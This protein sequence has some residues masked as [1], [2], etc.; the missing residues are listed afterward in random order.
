M[1]YTRLIIQLNNCNLNSQ[2]YKSSAM[3]IHKFDHF[4]ETTRVSDLISSKGK[5]QGTLY[6]RKKTLETRNKFIP[7]FHKRTNDRS[8]VYNYG[9]GKGV[10]K[11]E[12]YTGSHH[13]NTFECIFGSYSKYQSRLHICKYQNE[14]FFKC[15]RCKYQGRSFQELNKHMDHHCKNKTLA[16]AACN[17]ECFTS[18]ELKSD[19]NNSL[20]CSRC[21]YKCKTLEEMSMHLN[22]HANQIILK[23][24]SCSYTCFARS[25][26]NHYSTEHKIE[27][28]ALQRK[29]KEQF[30]VYE[31]DDMEALKCDYC[32]C[33]F[34]KFDAIK[35]NNEKNTLKQLYKCFLCGYY[36]YK[37]H[38]C[39][40]NSYKNIDD[41]GIVVF[42]C[43]DCNF[44][45]PLKSCFKRHL[46]IAHKN[47]HCDSHGRF[48][49]N[50]L[51]FLDGESRCGNIFSCAFCPFKESNLL[52]IRNHIVWEH[53]LTDPDTHHN[54]D[55]YGKKY[56]CN[57]CSFLA[58]ISSNADRKTNSEKIVVKCGFCSF[59]ASN[60]RRMKHHVVRKHSLTYLEY[61]AFDFVENRLVNSRS[62][63]SLLVQFKKGDKSKH[64]ASAW[65]SSYNCFMTDVL[66]NV[67]RETNSEETFK[68]GVCSCKAS[69]L[70]H[71][72]YHIDS[73]HCLAFAESNTFNKYNKSE[74][75]SPSQF[76]KHE[77]SKLGSSVHA[78]NDV[79]EKMKY[80]V[81]DY[82][83]FCGTPLNV[84]KEKAKR[85][86]KRLKHKQY[87]ES[88]DF[89]R[90]R[91]S[92]LNR[93]HKCTLCN[94][95]FEF[96]S[97]LRVHLILHFDEMNRILSEQCKRNL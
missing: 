47:T 79:D 13:M 58:D 67:D 51:S 84:L 70:R 3:N 19:R 86:K 17:Y 75:N 33:T 68:C 43:I 71:M 28:F 6:R 78:K 2:F 89:K 94:I 96:K 91:G 4:K 18:N 61:K 72:R 62:E 92:S 7:D 55:T 20:A 14:K 16:C 54:V 27:Y 40:V 21:D 52:R 60:L 59:K 41:S 87:S 37:I 44:K 29:S 53:G 48:L 45:T 1:R 39:L 23:C 31:S 22:R 49:T 32:D 46:N 76:K 50:T 15:T 56:Y 24:K 38:D 82:T 83:C 8:F 26:P 10:S 85:E 73:I 69:N 25:K 65:S 66:R 64:C 9:N 34:F 88:K 42:N 77:R 12:N 63:Q 74:Q 93:I 5:R 30:G 81:C 57:K 36:V 11:P 35:E 80:S 95:V 97:R 90:L